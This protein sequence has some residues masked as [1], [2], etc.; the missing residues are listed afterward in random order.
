MSEQAIKILV[1]DDHM[2]TAELI[3][4]VLESVGYE[5]VLAEGG[6]DALEKLSADPSFGLVVSDMHMPLVSGAELFQEMR[7][8]G[9]T[10]PFILLTGQDA[11]QLQTAHP[12]MD[13]VLKKDE[14]FQETL[15][16]LVAALL[17]RRS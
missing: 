14:S 16:D 8:Q 5:A 1:V 12:D 3:G 11:E 13:A 9:L 7:R 10:Q 17:A 6:V 15:P 4:L 2:F